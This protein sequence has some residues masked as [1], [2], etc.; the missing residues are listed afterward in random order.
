MSVDAERAIIGAVLLRNDS[1]GLVDIGPEDFSDLKCRAVFT[2][3]RSLD[4]K[5]S[6]IDPLLIEA[7]M[8]ETYA[9]VGDD[10][11]SEMACAVPTSDNIE[12]YAELV[13]SAA[14]NRA[15]LLAASEIVSR[16]KLDPG[17]DFTD[18]ASELMSTVAMK[19]SR[20][21]GLRTS[22]DIGKEVFAYLCDQTGSKGVPSGF[23]DIDTLLG[24]GFTPTNLIILAARPG[25]GKTSMALSAAI[26][27]ACLGHPVA[28]FSLEMSAS[29]LYQRALGAESQVDMRDVK[30]N[31]VNRAQMSNITVAVERL[32]TIPIEI[33][34]TPSLSVM[35]LRVRARKWKARN[36]GKEGMIFV[37][38]LQLMT[39]TGTKQSREQDVGQISRSLKAL[40]KE[41]EVPVM[42]MSQLNRGI[43]QRAEKR[44]VLSDLR[45]SGS[46]E[47]D[48]D[49]V[50]FIHR[51]DEQS[52]E[53]EIIV[54]KHRNGPTGEVKLSFE[55]RF[56]RFS[57]LKMIGYGF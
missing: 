39:V 40:A 22:K 31:R 53:A 44:P 37:D 26:N 11:I 30:A 29:E 55:P 4:A 46:I 13:R 5:R 51:P 56:T 19:G 8:G 57:N 50:M 23:A 34:D 20:R 45:E 42:A 49:M 48:A 14:T 10:S 32:G 33:D 12:H 15:V 18:W 6:A 25:V 27:A 17:E 1:L 35:E 41:L 16:G 38:Y 28:I 52:G 3:I 2:A 24:G 36:R 43:E 47:Q 7:E 9:A 21:G 54:A